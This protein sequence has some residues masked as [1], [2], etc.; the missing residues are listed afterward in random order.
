M[1]NLLLINLLLD[2]NYKR[3]KK[4]IKFKNLIL[5]NFYILNE[6]LNNIPIHFNSLSILKDLDKLVKNYTD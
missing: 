1:I 3:I 6:F 4:S 2:Y 5:I